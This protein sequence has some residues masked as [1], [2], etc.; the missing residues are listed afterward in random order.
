MSKIAPERPKLGHE[1]S[2][3]NI[4][5]ALVGGV[6]GIVGGVGGVLGGGVDKV[7]SALS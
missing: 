4:G 3:K 1:M 5:G 2:V 7:S 6:G